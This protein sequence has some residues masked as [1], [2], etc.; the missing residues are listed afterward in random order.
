MSTLAQSL[1][2]IQWAVKLHQAERLEVCLEDIPPKGRSSVLSSYG[3]MDPSV[4][5]ND[6]RGAQTMPHRLL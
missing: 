3:A 5:L 2:P 6:T 1:S 4:F